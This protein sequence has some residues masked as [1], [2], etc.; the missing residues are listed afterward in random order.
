[1]PY[2]LLSASANLL[3]L[4]WNSSRIA[5]ALLRDETPLRFLSHEV[6]HGARRRGMEAEDG[7]SMQELIWTLATLSISLGF[8]GIATA[9]HRLASKTRDVASALSEIATA[10]RNKK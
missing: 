8:I 4:L 6:P 2:S 1:M 9:I 10:I 3:F 7:E 5:L